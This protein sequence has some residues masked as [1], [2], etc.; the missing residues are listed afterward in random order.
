L[1]KKSQLGLIPM[2]NQRLRGVFDTALLKTAGSVVITASV[3][4]VG[5][6]AAGSQTYTIT[7]GKA[8]PTLAFSSPTTTATM[9]GTA[10]QSQATLTLPTN[11][12]SGGTLPASTGTLSYTSGTTATATVSNTGQITLVA[13][14]TTLIS[15]NVAADTNYNA[16]TA[17]SYTLTVSAPFVS[18]LPDTGITALQ[19]YGAGSNTLVDC[20]SIG[21]TSLSLTQ[22][23]MLG[24]DVDT[25]L[26]SDGKLGFS[27]SAVGSYLSTECV[28]D[29]I[30]GLTWEGKP[31]T[32]TRH[33]SNTYT[34]E[35]TAVSAAALEYVATVNSGAGL[36][37]FTDWRMPTAKEL[38][39]L[40]D[41][42][43]TSGALIDTTWFPNTQASYYW[44]STP[45]VGDADVAWVVNFY[46]GSVV[47][48]S[49]SGSYYVRLV[50]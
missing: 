36:C 44:S 14:G 32:V 50:R 45:F 18:P 5:T 17:A 38:Q 27:Y 20:T 4:A 23:G 25:P 47:N 3:P 26:A 15:A 7:I 49:R 30:T 28:K 21:A 35:D 48:D 41:Y 34:N 43:A 42:G 33:A 37:G 9:G 8:T 10:P 12:G 39:T 13:A 1:V 11:S 22:D 40:V 24:K 16:P 29:N 2:L 46:N 31:T 6:C 19:C